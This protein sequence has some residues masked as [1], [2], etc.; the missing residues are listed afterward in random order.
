[1]LSLSG[2]ATIVAKA[3]KYCYRL[4]HTILLLHRRC[5]NTIC[6][7]LLARI[8]ATEYAKRY[9]LHALYYR[10]M[11]HHQSGSEQTATLTEENF[12]APRL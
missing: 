5:V 1:M 2:I 3:S 11:L 9:F 7:L 4:G 12:V 10:A 6:N 8:P